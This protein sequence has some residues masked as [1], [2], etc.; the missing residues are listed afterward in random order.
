MSNKCVVTG[1][2]GFIGSYIQKE[3]LKRN[4]KVVVIDD[5]ST[6]EM[7]N[8]DP[9]SSFLL[10]DIS[11]EAFLDVS[12]DA[13]AGA[14]YVFHCASIPRTQYCVENPIE[15]NKANVAGTLNV[16][17]ASRQAGVDK[18]ILSSS[19]GIYG[20]GHDGSP[21]NE[22]DSINMGT[23]YSVQKYI[24]ELY[25]QLYH[26][27]YGLPS[28]MLRYFNVYGTKR[29]T[30]KGSYPNVLAA[31]SKAKRESG[32]IFVTG[33][34]TQS[35]DMIHVYDVVKAN[36][37][38]AESSFDCAEVFNVGTGKLTSVNE[39]AS[40]FNCPIEYIPKRPGEAK[41]LCANIDKITRL[42]EWQPSIGMEEGMKIYF[43]EK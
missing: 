32:K 6:G 28:V 10:E 18:L 42:L 26:D 38:A 22:E 5:L 37:M 7:E 8:I 43:N 31:F 25:T 30:E 33:D 23:P 36:I 11:D 2:A 16:L 4:F 19:C 24:Q 21:I 14:K 41:S 12:R 9:A 15:C 29:Q 39:M 34:G 13:F 1:G 3:L 17:E 20:P 27:I 35:R 40:Y